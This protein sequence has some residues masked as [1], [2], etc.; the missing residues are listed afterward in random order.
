VCTTPNV[1][2]PIDT[3][4]EAPPVDDPLGAL[5]EPAWDPADDLG[6]IVASGTYGPGYYSGGIN[7]L[8]GDVTLLPGIYVLDGPGV[9]IGAD[10]TFLAE[11]VMLFI[12]PGTG[13]IDISGTSSV[14]VT[15]PDPLEN[16]YPEAA[17]YEFVSIFQSRQN[18]N[19]SRIIGTGMLDL[20]G[21]LYFPSADLEIGGTGDG[22]GNQLIAHTLWIHGTAD[23]TINYDGH[24]PAPGDEVFLVE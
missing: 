6:A 5:P 14:R 11:G 24:F 18:S 7:L 12:P 1:D 10:T 20:N 22:F 8:G 23:I 21:T 2:T 19:P 4:T 9:N 17:T 3:W 16:S 13:F 15:P